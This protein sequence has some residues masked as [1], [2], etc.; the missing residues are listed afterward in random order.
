MQTRMPKKATYLHEQIALLR[1]RGMVITDE[2]KAEEILLD[3][4]YYRLGFYAY[5]FEIN[6]QQQPRDHTYKPDTDFNQIVELYYFDHDLR[7]ILMRYI[8]RI[9]VNIRTFITYTVSNYYRN[10]PTWFVNSRV[11]KADFRNNFEQKIYSTLRQNPCIA[12]HHHRY[13][14]DRFAPAWKTLEFMTLGSIITLFE[15][16]LD[17]NLKLQIAKHYGLNTI[18]L[19][20]NYLQTLKVIRNACAHGNH[21]FDLQLIKA[22]K[23]G[24]L[25]HFE[26]EHRHDIYAVL[27]VLLYFLHHISENREQE[28]RIALEKHLKQ[29][30]NKENVIIL[31][32]FLQK[33]LLYQK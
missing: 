14:N 9:E 31:N 23:K 15:S 21:I 19:F 33:V 2:Q 24:P 10:D 1:S 11:V 6:P 5:P 20:E 12:Y 3:V 16:L 30:K 29:P 7:H 25:Q 32:D 17:Q 18:P 13:H 8:S 27:L 22:V 28:L 4:G 26:A